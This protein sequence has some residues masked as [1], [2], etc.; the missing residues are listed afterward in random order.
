MGV[1]G[2]ALPPA[3]GPSISVSVSWA[4]PG[5]AGVLDVLASRVVRTVVVRL[6]LV[7]SAA[8]FF[9]LLLSFC[10]IG[11]CMLGCCFII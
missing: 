9:L 5:V 8:F 11:G 2:C 3:A 1:D 4:C 10:G 6:H 7:S